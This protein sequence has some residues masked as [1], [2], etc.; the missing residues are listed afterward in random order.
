MGQRLLT[1][2]EVNDYK[3]IIDAYHPGA[4]TVYDFARSRFAVIAGPTGAGK[5]TIRN[6]LAK[7]P[8]FIN[9]LSTT[10]RP[11]RPGEQEGVEYHFR[12]LKFFDQGFEEKRFLQAA[13]VHNQQISCL[14]IAEINKLNESQI[15]LS[16]LIVQTEIQLRSLNS[17]LKTIFVVPPS[18][19]I[20]DQRM[21]AGRG[22]SEEEI[23]RRMAAAKN[24]LEIALKQPDYY[25]VVN[26]ELASTVKLSKEFLESGVRDNV[27]ETEARNT[28]RAILDEL[29][30]INNGK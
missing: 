4:Q 1:E 11:L 19:A 20:L 17:D 7:S 27:S 8:Q 2:Q 12:D 9:I 23:A 29:G 25:C 10:S 13:V 3:N 26:E 5:D 24:E 14:D 16:I 18:L 15:G 21:R 6:E 22:E 28:I 30:G